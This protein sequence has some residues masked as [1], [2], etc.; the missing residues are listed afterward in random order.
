MGLPRP[1]LSQLLSVRYQVGFQFSAVRFRWVH[2][3]VFQPVVTG[4]W[5]VFVVCCVHQPYVLLVSLRLSLCVVA[6][7]GLSHLDRGVDFFQEEI[8][9]I[10]EVLLFRWEVQCIY[11]S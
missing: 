7:C 10:L 11:T 6:S 3:F 2:G 1:F 8:T 4:S 9:Q 5:V